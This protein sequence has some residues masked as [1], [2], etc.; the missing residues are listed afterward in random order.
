MIKIDSIPQIEKIKEGDI[1][2]DNST[3]EMTHFRIHRISKNTVF[4]VHA[5]GEIAVKVFPID[6]LI[7]EDWWLED[8]KSG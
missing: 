3:G 2:I 8:R 6:Q 5:D 7:N 1:I 4:A